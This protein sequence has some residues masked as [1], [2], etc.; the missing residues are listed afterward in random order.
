MEKTIQLNI[1]TAILIFGLHL[2]QKNILW[3]YATQENLIC[4]VAKKCIIWR[5]YHNNQNKL[6]E[7]VNCNLKPE[8]IT[9]TFVSAQV[10]WS[11][12]FWGNQKK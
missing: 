8:E 7:K 4:P 6:F 3:N 5:T 11:W 2:C 1:Q 12:V 10:V 9:C